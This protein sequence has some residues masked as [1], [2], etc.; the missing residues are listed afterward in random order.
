MQVNFLAGTLAG[1]TAVCAT[2]PLDTVRARMAMQDASGHAKSVHHIHLRMHI[3]LHLHIHI[4]IHL[5]MHAHT[6]IH[7]IHIHIHIHRHT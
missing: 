6:C 7:S 4:H 3:H 2:Y 5:H 1:I